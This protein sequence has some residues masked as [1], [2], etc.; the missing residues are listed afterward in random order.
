MEEVMKGEVIL[1]A[2]LAVVAIMTL[3]FGFGVKIF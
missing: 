3:Q 1:G 2:L